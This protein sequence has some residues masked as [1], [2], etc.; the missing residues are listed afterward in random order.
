MCI[1]KFGEY[2]VMELDKIGQI[3]L[4]MSDYSKLQPKWNIFWNFSSC[5]SLLK[6]TLY[7]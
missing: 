1:I 7:T 6:F 4:H 5:R 2:F 3:S